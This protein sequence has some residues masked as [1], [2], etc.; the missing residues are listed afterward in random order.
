MQTPSGTPAISEGT[1]VHGTLGRTIALAV[2]LAVTC[3]GIGMGY[4]KLGGRIDNLSADVEAHKKDQTIHLDQLWQVTHG[5]PIGAFD[6][7][8]TI[9]RLDAIDKKLENLDSKTITVCRP[10]AG[11]GMTCEPKGD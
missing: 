2:G 8:T 6:F 7:G 10:R 9:T 11:G 1:K 5:R 3:I 4:A